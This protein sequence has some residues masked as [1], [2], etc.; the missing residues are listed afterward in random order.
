MG[1]PQHQKR[2]ASVLA[3][4]L[5]DLEARAETDPNDTAFIQLKSQLVQRI[6]QLEADS[7]R[8]RALIHLVDEPKTAAEDSAEPDSKSQSIA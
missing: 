4:T 3:K 1:R 8:A 7:T 2:L 6:I 5:K